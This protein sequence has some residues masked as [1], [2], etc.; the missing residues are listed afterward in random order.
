MRKR[1]FLVHPTMLAMPPV[2][3]AFKTLWPDATIV[4]VLDES[5]YND[6]PQDGKLA[7][8]IFTRLTSLFR[9]C[10][11]SRADGIVFSGSTFG[12]A[13]EDARRNV[14]IPVL[15]IEEAMMDDAAARGGSILLVCT[16]KRAQPV[17]R[18]TL[19]A[20][21]KQ[22]GKPLTVTE[23]WVS[24]ARD[25]LNRGD[26]ATH[27]R[28]IAEQTA[29]AGDFDQIVF[30]MMSMAP[31]KA[32]MPAALAAKVFTAGEAAVAR[33]QVLTSGSETGAITGME[34]PVHPR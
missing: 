15:R 22:A 33:M 29:A 23:L 5:L 24:G 9:H 13:V 4:N 34:T 26:N 27:D 16:Q 19:D 3:Q 30:G 10:E 14:G 18:G 8:E 32:K 7:P 28:L 17:V 2:D 20:A 31:A 1:I 12:P 25:A 6:I 11:A 21:A